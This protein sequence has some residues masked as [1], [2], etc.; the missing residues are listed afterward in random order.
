IQLCT[1]LIEEDGLPLKFIRQGFISLNDP[2]IQFERLIAERK[3]QHD[4]NPIMRWCLGNAA[5]EKDAA[6]NVK[7]SKKKSR[8]KIDGAAAAVN[9]VAALISP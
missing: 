7:L 8:E 4:G 3:I 5:A 1:Q 6:G 2:T 9:A